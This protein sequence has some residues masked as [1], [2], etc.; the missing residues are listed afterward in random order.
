M[1]NNFE[2]ILEDYNYSLPSELIAQ[3]PSS[4]RDS[5]R[6]LVYDRKTNKIQL[7]TFLNL[8]KYLPK[9]AVLVFNQTKVIPARL[10]LYKQSG[11]KV[12]VLYIGRQNNL[13]KVLANKNLP[14]QTKLY[15]VH[16]REL[17]KV[18]KKHQGIYFLKPSTT[19][20]NFQSVISKFGLT[21]LPPYMKHSSLTEKQRRDAYQTIFAKT[22]ESVAAPTASLHFTNR[23]LAKLKKRGIAIKFVRLD[24]NLGTFAPLKENQFKIKKLHKEN[25]FIDNATIKSIQK[26]KKENRPIFA[27]GTTVVRTLESYALTKKSSGSTELFI[28]PGYNF[29][30]V[31]GMIT[32]FHVPKSSLLMLVSALI[33]REKLLNAYSLAIKEKFKF[34][35]F[36]DGM[37]II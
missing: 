19:V 22:G 15:I 14:L 12:E 34:F 10:P 9:N 7:D 5:A 23:L 8:P 31:D 36:G 27:V 6:L 24:V 16:G 4:P 28:S 33:S 20:S 25:Y 30:L 35:S 17:C 26:A 11:G 1:K 2:K 3:K 37:L 21:P 13:F 32:N 18:V 29:K